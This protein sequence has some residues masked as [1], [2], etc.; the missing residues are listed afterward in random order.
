[1]ALFGRTP[2]HVRPAGL[3]SLVAFPISRLEQSFPEEITPTHPVFFL[4][5]RL[6]LILV[7]ELVFDVWSFFFPNDSLSERTRRLFFLQ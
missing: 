1:M 6:G 7:L 4:D 3:A 2:Q 5:T